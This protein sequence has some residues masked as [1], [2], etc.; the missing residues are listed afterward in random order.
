MQT[1][2]RSNILVL[3]VLFFIA[4]STYAMTLKE[5]V[6]MAAMNN[7]SVQAAWNAFHASGDG[8]R[9]AEGGFLP[10]LDFNAEVGSER[11][12]NQQNISRNYTTNSYRLTL[13]QMLFD[14]FFTKEDVAKQKFF[15]LAKY[16]E[17]RQISEDIA[18][19][20]AQ[21]YLD[22]LRY[23][24]LV[25]LTKN[26]YRQ[27]LRYHSD[28]E[29]RAKTGFGRG[30]DLDQSTAR[31][32][33]AEANVLT[34]ITNLHDVSARFLRLVG[35]LPPMKLDV[36][37]LPEQDI[38]DNL[39]DTLLEAYGSNPSLNA[40]IESIRVAK[41]D[42]RGTKAPMMPRFDLRLRKQIDDNLQG[43]NGQYDEEAI[44]LVA[45]Y[46]LYRGGSDRARRRQSKNL[47]FEAEDNRDRV[48]REV[49][50]I[51]TIAYNDIKTT[52]QLIAFLERNET[53]ISRARNAY[54]KQFDIGKRTLLD[55]LDSENEYFDSQRN[56]INGKSEVQAAQIRTLA[57]MGKLLQALGLDNTRD[58][59]QEEL[60][61]EREEELAARCPASAPQMEP[62]DLDINSIITPP[63]QV[64]PTERPRKGL[65]MDVNF[66]HRSAIL[67]DST[68]AEI[69]KAAAFLCSH[70]DVFAMLEGH[71]DSTGSESF[72]IILSEARAESV[73][74]AII[75]QCADSESRI[76]TVGRGETDSIASN[77]TEEGRALNRRVELIMEERKSTN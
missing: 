55:L 16:Y 47:V 34:E 74:S 52:T 8:L 77:E 18:E 30:V 33:L 63:D 20:T 49:R 48:C 60:Q 51:V 40:S 50:Q 59:D 32:A 70:P 26:N 43:V 64:S 6:D 56:L 14:G 68:T 42:F 69:V 17:F 45:G 15:Q 67:N 39:K 1:L 75:A 37:D 3:A 21:A 4:G 38:P 58:L 2:Y 23:R 54:Q 12:E 22:I 13:T 76:S 73:K 65:R 5:A 41:A 24:K 53:A 28:I 36:P 29:S 72:N 11:Y 9:A 62:L 35:I 71:T 19:E 66:N 25:E 10:T 57:G 46:N 61:V 27:H 44:E 31:L 7:P